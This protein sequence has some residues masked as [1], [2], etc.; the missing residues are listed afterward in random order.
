MLAHKVLLISMALFFTSTWCMEINI[1]LEEKKSAEDIRRVENRRRSSSSDMKQEEEFK[2][3]I[4]YDDEPQKQIVLD[5]EKFEK[6]YKQ[7]IQE[8]Q[9]EK[10][11]KHVQKIVFGGSL[12]LV[13]TAIT[14]LLLYELFH[15]LEYV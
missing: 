12:C 13:Y 2:E 4:R 10:C 7:R 14:G 15:Y 6:I 8:E 9:S 3:E 11:D 1:A 5:M